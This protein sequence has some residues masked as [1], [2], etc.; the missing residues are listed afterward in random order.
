M[1][2]NGDHT[3][4]LNSEAGKSMNK[5]KTFLNSAIVLYFVICFE[6]LIMISPF[7]GFFYSAFNPFLLGLAKY[8]ATS[9]LS[10]FFFTHMV[11]PPSDFLKFVRILG[12]VLFSVGIVLFLICAFQVYASKFLRRGPTIKGL[13]SLIRHPQYVALATAGAGLAILWPRFLVLVLWLAMVLV[14]YLL[15]RDE[16]DRM[17]KQHP[18][19]Y[20]DYMQRTGMFL[21]RRIENAVPLS[22][23]TS[24]AAAF[25]L[26]AIFVM[27]GAFLLRQYTV[28][29]LP[30]GMNSRVVALSVLAEDEHM[31]EHRMGDVLS[32]E[33]IQSRLEPNQ[34]YLVYFLPTNYVMQGLIA[35]TGGDW[36]LYKRHHT[37]SRFGD[38]IF[39]PFTHLGGAH[40]SAFEPGGHS[41]HIAGEGSV[42]RLIFVKISATSVT[43]PADAFSL[44][45]IRTPDFMVDVDVHNLTV[46]GTKNLPVET[47]WG[48]VPTPTF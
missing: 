9:W 29:H 48:K 36:Q 31:M 16:E 43:K 47:A 4:P 11:V 45:A 2:S 39:H 28:D 5:S 3:E 21:P 37:I 15:A 14:Y 23:I 12:S 19:A 18:A 42:R 38:W 20:R 7:A 17:Q 6:I 33:Q 1:F 24:R 30:L 41:H 34:T 25:L 35:D 46:L 10:A 44:R 22:T 27:G 8:R 13:Y 32:L 26:L 40:A